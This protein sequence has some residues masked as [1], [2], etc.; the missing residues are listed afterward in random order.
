MH[1]TLKYSILAIAGGLIISL[2]PI[3]FFPFSEASTLITVIGIVYGVIA[4]FLISA[5][6]S[7]FNSIRDGISEEVNSFVA[8]ALLAKRMNNK[9]FLTKVKKAL[10][11]YSKFLADSSVRS[12]KDSTDVFAHLRNLS[13]TTAEAPV[14]N[15]KQQS[16][17]ELIEGEVSTAATAK[18][19]QL[20]VLH[21]RTSFVE[22][23]LVIFFSIFLLFLVVS[24]QIPNTNYIE[25]FLLTAGLVT[26]ILL[27]PVALYHVDFMA[28][29]AEKI[30]TKPYLDVIDIINSNTL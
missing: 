10:C 11:S 1:P 20:L 6:D 13:K 21:S 29:E 14:K 28:I 5:A 30:S 15:P 7:R 27:L 22:W 9:N 18:Q 3:R 2:N 19:R 12:L 16:L 8:I 25:T 26:A 23:I 4:A 17:F 24:M